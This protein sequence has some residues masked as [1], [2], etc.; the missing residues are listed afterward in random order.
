MADPEYFKTIV[1]LESVGEDLGSGRRD[2]V[3]GDV[4]MT[5]CFV[6]THTA[7]ERHSAVVRQAVVRQIHRRQRFAQLDSQQIVHTLYTTAQPA[8]TIYQQ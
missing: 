6:D 7:T 4:E 8:I 5:Q 3:I 2:S 1:L